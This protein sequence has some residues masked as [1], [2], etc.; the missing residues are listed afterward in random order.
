MSFYEGLR[1]DT[2]APL[3]AQFGQ[4][5]AYRIDATKT[6][7]NAT[8]KVTAGTPDSTPIKLLDLPL[9]DREFSE[10]VVAVARGMFLV[11]AK[12]LNEAAVVPAVDAEIILA[13]RAYRI[14]AINTV[15]PAGI[16]VIYKMAVS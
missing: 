11:S 9:R 10:E 6:Y 8:G 7:D 1:D 16:A 15:G 3:I 2:A 14:R 5:A 13:G 12:E 4:V